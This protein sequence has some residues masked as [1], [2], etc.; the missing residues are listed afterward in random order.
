[1][2]FALRHLSVIRNVVAQK[3]AA[4]SVL[5]SKLDYSLIPILRQ[6]LLQ[7]FSNDIFLNK[8]LTISL[9]S[10]NTGRD[11]FYQGINIQYNSQY[12]D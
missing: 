5:I 11:L 7:G 9:I 10:H 2:N 6:I 8:H 1:M 4:T 12:S 3:W